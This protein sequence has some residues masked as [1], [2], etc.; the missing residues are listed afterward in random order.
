M[1]KGVEMKKMIVLSSIFMMVLIGCSAKEFN[2]GV[3]SVTNDVSSAF[4]KGQ[5]K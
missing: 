2:E 3:D 1:S 4:E 5:D